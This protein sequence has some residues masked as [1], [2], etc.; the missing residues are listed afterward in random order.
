MA[1]N[2]E[3][4]AVLVDPYP[5]WLDAVENVLAKNAV[6]V[7]GRTSSAERAVALCEELRP[8]ILVAEPASGG[9]AC[10]REATS[11]IPGLKAIAL[12]SSNDPAQVQAAFAA[13]AVA[14]VVKTAHPDDVGVAI[15]QTFSPSLF[16]PAVAPA[17]VS[18]G[19]G[20]FADSHPAVEALT[21]RER[22][23]LTLVAEGHSNSQLA[24]MLWVTEQTVKFH[25]SNIYRKLEVANRTEAS[26]WAQLHG[27]L[28]HTP[29]GS[30]AADG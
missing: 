29:S 23:I 12:A 13:G 25:L 27:L 18:N 3:R 28:E 17:A 30:I 4:T 15:R 1:F 6:S 10:I 5:L 24:R 7:V 26:R 14:Y 20:A 21:K 11:R 8:G 9:I 2:G 22:E 19:N 16:L